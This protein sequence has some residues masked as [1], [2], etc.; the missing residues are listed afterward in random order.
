MAVFLEDT[1]HKMAYNGT[2]WVDISAGF[3]YTAGNG[4][5]LTNNAFSAVAN[6]DAGIAVDGNGIAAVV[7]T[8]SIVF[9]GNGA[10]SAK[11]KANDVLNV[12]S[13]YGL[14]VALDGSTVVKN[15][16]NQ[17][18]VNNLDFGTW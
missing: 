3:T 12:D 2:S 11:V 8:T 10:I 7:D 5:D 4:I 9:D 1:D 15:A 17:I 13:T 6:G 16:S 14:N 18:E